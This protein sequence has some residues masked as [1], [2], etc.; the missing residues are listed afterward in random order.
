MTIVEE[1]TSDAGLAISLSRVE[2]ELAEL[3]AAGAARDELI[4]AIEESVG[5]R[6]SVVDDPEQAREDLL[7][8]LIEPG[9]EILG[10]LQSDVPVAEATAELSQCLRY[11]ARVLG[12]ELVRE[13]ATREA[14]WSLEA[15]LLAELIATDDEIPERLAQRAHHAG[16]DLT[17]G[18]HLLMLEAEDGP[19]PDLLAAAARRPAI[20]GERAMSCAMGER[21]AVAV[22]ED[23]AEVLDAKVRDLHR[24]ARGLG[25]VLHVGVSS[26]VTNFARG[27][28]QAEAALRLARCGAEASTMYHKDL[29]SL[30]FLLNAPN[31]SELMSLVETQIGPLAAHDRERQTYLLQTLEVFLDEGGNRRRTAERC[32]VHESTIKYRMRRIRELLGCDLTSANVRFDLMLGLKVLALLRAVDAD[33]TV[34]TA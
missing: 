33:P 5:C 2:A 25:C 16:L 17:R 26:P 11:G 27:A 1:L 9:T 18:W 28:R 21:L 12:I 24:I 13:R 10:Y 32:H 23:P 3:V 29:G 6:L 14:R 8:Q 4:V 30:R 22:C 31:E 20:A 7:G 15:D 19:S 34:R